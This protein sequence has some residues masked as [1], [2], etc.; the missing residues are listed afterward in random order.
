M[1]FI[2]F[3]PSSA[4]ICVMHNNNNVCVFLSVAN[5]VQISSGLSYSIGREARQLT[6]DEGLYLPSGKLLCLW[7]W[8]PM[9]KVYKGQ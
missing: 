5:F 1:I 4:R 8:K 7:T 9:E 3:F 6:G 2:Q